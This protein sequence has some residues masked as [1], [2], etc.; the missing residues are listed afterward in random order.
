M[1][2]TGEEKIA[3]FEEQLSIIKDTNIREFTKLCIIMA[4]DYFFTSCP[5]SS[6]GKY[7][8]MDELSWDGTMI[9][10]KKVCKMGVE[11]TR[12]FECDGSQ[13][14]VLSA[15]IIHD[16]RKQGLSNAGRTVS[17]HPDLAAKLVEEVQESTMLLTDKSFDIIRKC[18]GYHYGPWSKDK[19]KKSISEYTPEELSVFIADYVVSRRFVKIV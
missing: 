14:E 15:C 3:V 1:G 13:D 4:P 17:D 8:P 6:S 2:I 12:A 9:H 5:A 7:H 16:L 18:V 19:W 10:T 11:L